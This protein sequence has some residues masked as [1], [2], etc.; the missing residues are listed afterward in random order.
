MAKTKQ[1]N[2]QNDALIFRL[3]IPDFIWKYLIL[4]N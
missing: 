3:F 2:G 4:K 1:K